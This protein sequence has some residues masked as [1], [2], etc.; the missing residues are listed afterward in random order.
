MKAR[1]CPFLP[2]PGCR[3]GLEPTVSEYPVLVNF[4]AQLRVYKGIASFLGH[5]ENLPFDL[6]FLA[7]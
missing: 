7:L 5:G 3:P 1:Q 2:W 6:P 4:V